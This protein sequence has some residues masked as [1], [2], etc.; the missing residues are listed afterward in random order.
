MNVTSS[1]PILVVDDEQTIRLGFSVALRS[2]GFE[3]ELAASG[4]EAIEM[5]EQ[6]QPD[7][8]LLDLRMP[9]MDGLQTAKRIREGGFTGPMVLS[10]AFAD[11]HTAIE[12]LR[13]GI[14]DFLTKPVK[15]TQL[16]YAINH[17][18]SRHTRFSN[19]GPVDLEK[20]S[21][22]L[23]RAYAKYCL[24]QRW[25]DEAFAALRISAAERRD[26]QSLLLLGAMFEMNG[27]LDS[28]GEMFARATELH[29]SS[30]NLA[31]STELFRVFSHSDQPIED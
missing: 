6:V 9:G 4:E 15:P 29:A 21:P 12:A 23:L 7:C 30:I 22:D 19:S 5:A 2:A 14:T 25:H 1:H 28:A 10:S 31:A 18:L 26:L 16:R 8:V 24:S 3:V 13:L 27:D 17:S 11:H 20:L